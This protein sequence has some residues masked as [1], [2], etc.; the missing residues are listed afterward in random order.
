METIVAASIGAAGLVASTLL[1]TR[2]AKRIETSLG[3]K[4]G[5]GSAIEMLEHL[6]AWTIRHEGRHDLLERGSK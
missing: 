6:K 4:N 3:T 5:Q 2:R 1:N